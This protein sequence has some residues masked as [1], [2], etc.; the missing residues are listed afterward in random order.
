M[1]DQEKPRR[2][3]GVAWFGHISTRGTCTRCGKHTRVYQGYNGGEHV[4]FFCFR[5]KQPVLRGEA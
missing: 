4:A 1:T 3:W 2:D 5:C